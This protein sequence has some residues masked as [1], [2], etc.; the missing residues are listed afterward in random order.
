MQPSRNC[1][2]EVATYKTD[3]VWI[4]IPAFN[5]AHNLAAVIGTVRRRYRNIVLVDDGSVDDTSAAALEVGVWCLRHV[6][7]CGQ[8][9]ALQTGIDF[10]LHR[11]ARAVVTFDA[12][13]QHS[14]DEIDKLVG[15][16]LAGEVDVC[17]GS[18][19]L[20]TAIGLTWD[21][22]IVLKLA[23]L[24]TRFFARIPLTDT[25]N[26]FRAV[27]RRAAECFRL[28][29]D[30]MAHAS[31]IL[32]RISQLELTFREIPVT[33]TYTIDSKRKGQRSWN[34][35]GIVGELFFQRFLR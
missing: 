15:P 16:V 31:E 29:Q 1:A 12:D 7:N 34:F 33:I 21:R 20:G 5:E 24:F 10:A 25:H 22:W 4:I 3:D 11:G 32:H 27:S 23:V 19:F 2:W 8:G 6:V 17:L 13:G 28:E 14:A 18:R 35:V 26:G 30:R 9:A